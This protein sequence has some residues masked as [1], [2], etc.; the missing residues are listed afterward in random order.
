MIYKK[1]RFKRMR[2]NARLFVELILL[3]LLVSAIILMF[4]LWLIVD[5]LGVR[6]DNYAQM[7]T[8]FCAIIFVIGGIVFEISRIIIKKL[9]KHSDLDFI[10]K[11]MQRL[12]KKK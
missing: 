6:F 5:P 12:K 2:I 8:I 1:T 11:M 10:Q 7:I 3:P 9:I 4:I